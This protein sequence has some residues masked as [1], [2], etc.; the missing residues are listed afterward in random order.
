MSI[1]VQSKTT[2]IINYNSVHEVSKLLV[3]ASDNATLCGLTSVL[4]GGIGHEIK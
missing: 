4:D 2:A 1:S 3:S